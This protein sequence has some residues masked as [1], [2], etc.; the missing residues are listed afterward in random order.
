MQ[1]PFW[2]VYE[3]D[4]PMSSPHPGIWFRKGCQDGAAGKPGTILNE[5]SKVMVS[6]GKQ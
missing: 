1:E 2:R 5:V 3:D 4:D 6:H